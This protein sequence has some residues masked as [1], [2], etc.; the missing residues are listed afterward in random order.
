MRRDETLPFEWI[1]DNTRDRD[2]PS[3][4]FDNVEDALAYLGSLKGKGTKSLQGRFLSA[5]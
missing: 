1:V 5:E 4:T 2:H 3:F